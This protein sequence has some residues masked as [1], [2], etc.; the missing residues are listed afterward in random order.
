[1]VSS[2]T[3][4]GYTAFSGLMARRAMLQLVVAII[5]QDHGRYLAQRVPS[6]IRNT[7]VNEHFIMDL[8]IHSKSI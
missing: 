3:L 7:I 6:A 4:G 8:D 1:M 2:L 5:S